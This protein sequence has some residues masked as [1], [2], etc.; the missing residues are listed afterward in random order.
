MKTKVLGCLLG[1]VT[2]IAGCQQ[3]EKVAPHQDVNTLYERFHGRYK[4]I[5]STSNEA[6]DVNED[7]KASTNMLEEIPE[8]PDAIIQLGI[9]GKNQYNPNTSFFFIHHWPKQEL[10]LHGIRIEPTEYNPDIR[11]MFSTKVVA[12]AFTFD[13]DITQLILSPSSAILTDPDI[14]TP[15]Q[16]VTIT[17]NNQIEVILTKRLYTTSGMKT[18]QIVTLYER[19]TM[20]T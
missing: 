20:T 2:I 8:L 6:I 15:P 19:Y 7:G 12:W 13:P 18:V 17:T 3:T 16:A 11:A 1:L 4:I 5:H 9:Y 14:F 10:D